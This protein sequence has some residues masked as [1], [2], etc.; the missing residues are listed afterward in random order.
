V[1]HWRTLLLVAGAMAA[2]TARRPY[3]DPAY[4]RLPRINLVVVHRGGIA[5]S[6]TVSEVRYEVETLLASDCIALAGGPY[7]D[8]AP[9]FSLD[10]VDQGILPGASRM[11]DLPVANTALSDPYHGTSLDNIVDV[12]DVAVTGGRGDGARV[13]AAFIYMRRAHE[14]ET[15]LLGEFRTVLGNDFASSV[16]MAEMIAGLIRRGL[17]T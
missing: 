13:F 9:E 17:S 12:G 14:Q 11:V 5:F 1:S 10:L 16:K 7:D 4:A 8:G 15:V 6:R 2:C 3:E